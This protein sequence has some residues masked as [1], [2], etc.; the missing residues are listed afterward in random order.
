METDGY[1]DSSAT[2]TKTFKGV[3]KYD[4]V[5]SYLSTRKGML[6]VFA[7]AQYGTEVRG[8]AVEHL[9]DDG[10][11]LRGVSNTAARAGELS[12]AAAASAALKT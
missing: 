7:T 9:I 11:M 8:L 2:T 10:C 5:T 3:V 12:D 1:A 6:K 4:G